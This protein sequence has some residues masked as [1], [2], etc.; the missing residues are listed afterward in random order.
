MITHVCRQISE[1]KTAFQTKIVPF[2]LFSYFVSLPR[3]L[4]FLKIQ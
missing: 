1:D 3:N 2:R 4:F